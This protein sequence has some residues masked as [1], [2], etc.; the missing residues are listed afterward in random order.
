MQG[1]GLLL[2]IVQ[3]PDKR[4]YVAHQGDRLADGFVKGITSQGLVLVRNRSDRA[5]VQSQREV[6]KLL[7]SPEDGKE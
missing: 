4:S 6:L 5:A 1:R 2:A 3:G 7:G